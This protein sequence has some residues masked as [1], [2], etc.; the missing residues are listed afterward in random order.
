MRNDK[1][2]KVYYECECHSYDHAFFTDQYVDDEPDGW[3]YFAI[4]TQLAPINNFF[5]RVRVAVKYIINPH[6]NVYSHWHETELD[7][8]GVQR[9]M[10]EC[11]RYLLELAERKAKGEVE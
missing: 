11:N 4:G 10:G 7:E 3:S 9:L 8:A 5:K 2:N 1:P 6:D